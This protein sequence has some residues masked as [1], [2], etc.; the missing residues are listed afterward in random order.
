MARHDPLVPAAKDRA[1]HAPWAPAASPAGS[2][3]GGIEAPLALGIG[4]LAAGLVALFA[5]FAVAE[6]RRR[7]S[8]VRSRR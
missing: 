5:G 8:P 4:L 3:S 6:V 1:S 2:G 7:R